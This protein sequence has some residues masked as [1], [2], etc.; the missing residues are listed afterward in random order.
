MMLRW[1][2][3]EEGSSASWVAVLHLLLPA[4]GKTL[5]V[6]APHSKLSALSAAMLGTRHREHEG[7]ASENYSAGPLRSMF[8]TATMDQG[9]PRLCCGV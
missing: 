3:E 4:R 5:K 1:S 8:Q 9:K 6:L 2:K 7:K